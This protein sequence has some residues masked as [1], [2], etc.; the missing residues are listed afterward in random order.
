MPTLFLDAGIPSSLKLQ[1][2][3][4]V[5]LLLMDGTENV[6]TIHFKSLLLG[7]ICTV[8]SPSIWVSL[9]LAE[10]ERGSKSLSRVAVESS[11]QPVNVGVIAES[12]AH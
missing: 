1:I 3:L 7:W 4:F 11:W 10:R 5:L 12:V 6:L 2:L 9:L 8:C